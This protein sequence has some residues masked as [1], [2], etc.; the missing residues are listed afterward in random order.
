MW[1]LPKCE[2]VQIIN[3][4][5]KKYTLYLQSRKEHDEEMRKQYEYIGKSLQRN[6]QLMMAGI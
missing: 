1:F 3:S 6:F 5:N 4:F 2:N